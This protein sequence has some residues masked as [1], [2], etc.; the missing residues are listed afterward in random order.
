L[1][2][3]L[4]DLAYSEPL[5]L[6]IGLE[7]ISQSLASY[8]VSEPTEELALD[9]ISNLLDQRDALLLKL[10]QILDQILQDPDLKLRLETLSQRDLILITRAKQA[11]QNI[12]NQMQD[13][14]RGLNATSSY[15]EQGSLDETSVY[16]ENKG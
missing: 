4:N 5:S 15:L 12:Q 16:F 3:E 6:L 10:P 9:Y 14:G 2:D 11:L 7:T 1:P 13:L 8:L